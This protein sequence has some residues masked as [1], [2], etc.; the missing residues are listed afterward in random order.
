M[1]IFR[2]SPILTTSEHGSIVGGSD[3]ILAGVRVGTGKL[4][5]AYAASESATGGA[6]NTVRTAWIHGYEVNRLSAE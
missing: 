6:V 2:A 4:L 5:C 1:I 3:H